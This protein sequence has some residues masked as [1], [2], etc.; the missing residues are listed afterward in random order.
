MKPAELRQWRLSHNLRTREMLA[1]ELGVP[2]PTVNNWERGR[3]AIPAY[4]PLA[5]ETV[6]RR[7]AEK[8][9]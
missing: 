1:V 7:I 3:N 2:L 9:A 8:S 6:A 4:L 5:L